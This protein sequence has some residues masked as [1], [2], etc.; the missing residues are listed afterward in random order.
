M[1]AEEG[2]EMSN[3]NM[4]QRM[5][6]AKRR[7]MEKQAAQLFNKPIEKLTS[8]QASMCN[9]YLEFNKLQRFVE[10]ML[11]RPF[12]SV[13]LTTEMDKK[14]D[15]IYQK[16]ADETTKLNLDKAHK[17]Y[18]VYYNPYVKEVFVNG[19]ERTIDPESGDEEYVKMQKKELYENEMA[20]SDSN[21]LNMIYEMFHDENYKIKGLAGCPLQPAL[22]VYIII[23]LSITCSVMA[24]MLGSVAALSG[25]E[26]FFDV[27]EAVV[28]II[29]TVEYCIKVLVV[30]DRVGYVLD[31]MNL[32]DLAAIVPFYVS[33][34]MTKPN[35]TMTTIGGVLRAV[36]LTRIAKIRQLATPY[37]TIILSALMDS[38]R[39]TGSVI[40]IFLF[41]AC[42][43]CGTLVYAA[44][45]ASDHG[46]ELFLSIPA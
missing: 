30:R 36:R 34:G 31:V 4:L 8:A 40:A 23:V 43:F 17:P 39:G 7:L 15:Y 38:V 45:S 5:E 29:F 2:V 41:I 37:T 35:K 25:L 14:L 18:F 3:M 42:V 44:E 10:S 46:N 28:T 13:F 26:G 9:M 32:L 12:E 24:T 21:Q 11:P 16:N 22:I 1:K 20:I 6:F 19:V 27:L 33:L